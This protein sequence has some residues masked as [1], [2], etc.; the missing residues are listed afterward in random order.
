MSPGVN[1]PFGRHRRRLDHYQSHPARR[2]APEM[3]EMPVIRHP[4]R[5]GILAHRRHDDPVPK[6]HVAYREL[7]QKID[8]RNLAIVLALRKTPTRGAGC[9]SDPLP[10]LVISLNYSPPSRQPDP[11]PR[12]PFDRENSKEE[13]Q[14]PRLIPERRLD[15]RASF[16]WCERATSRR[17]HWPR[18][19]QARASR[20]SCELFDLIARGGKLHTL[21]ASRLTISI[22]ASGIFPFSA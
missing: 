11:L 7:T 18:N 22:E 12:H 3:N 6:R 14:E 10:P 8:I 9:K 17:A 5:R 20:R 4:V 1:P 15:R 21:R 19:R 2:P 13:H 16:A